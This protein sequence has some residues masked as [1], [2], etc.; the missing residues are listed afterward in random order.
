ML[1]FSYRFPKNQ[2]TES[3]SLFGDQVLKSYILEAQECKALAEQLD[4]S[5]DFSLYKNLV[6]FLVVLSPVI[7]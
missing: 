5:L 6:K 1:K 3:V 4:F 7:E 2:M